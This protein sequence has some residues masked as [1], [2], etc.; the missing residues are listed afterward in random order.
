[1]AFRQIKAPALANAA[2]INTKLAPSAV[3]G[4]EAALAVNSIS[5]DTL[6]LHVAGTDTLAK[7]TVSHLVGSVDTDDLTEGAANLYFTDLRAQTAVAT[8]IS[9][10][11]AAEA[12]LARAAEGVNAT[13]I[14]AEATTARAAEG[15][16][17]TAISAEVT[18]AS[19]VES[20]LDAAYKLADTGL[21]TQI[22]N[23]L[24]NTDETALNSLA[25][26]VAAYESADDIFTAGI[27]AN[28]NAISAETTARI[29]D[30]STLTT[31]LGLTQDELDASQVGA[32]LSAAGAYIVGAATNYLT[33]ATSLSDAD[34]KLDAQSKANADAIAAEVTRATG[35]ESTN[36]TNISTNVT[37][38]STNATAISD[39]ASTARTNETALSDDI[40]AEITARGDADTAVRSEFAAA[41]ALQTT[42]LQTYADTAEADA[43]ATASAD[44]TTKADAA[45]TDAIAS[46]EAKDVARA[47][48]SD[49]A[50]TA[51]AGRATTLETEMDTAEGR[52]DTLEASGGSADLDTIDQTVAGGINE[53]HTD[54]NAV[55]VRV[56]TAETDITT[57][58]TAIANILTNTDEVA[59]NSLAELV[60]EFQA[61]DGTIT[62]LVNAN[63]TAISTEKARA[64]GVEA[65]NASAI[66]TEASTARAA[67]VVNANAVVT[68]AGTR[69]TADTTLQGNI[70]A[71]A[72]TRG[73]ADTAFQTE[74]DATQTG[75]G[76]GI[77]GTY[78]AT[79]A[80]NYIAAAT[81]LKDA[82]VKL[83]TQAKVN[84]D[85]IAAEITRATGVEGTNAT[86][87]ATNVSD[88][89]TNATNIAQEIVDRGI[90]DVALQ[91]NIDDVQAE[92][93]TTQAG[94]GLA[95]TGAYAQNASANYIAAAT[96]LNDADVKLDAALKVEEVRALAAEGINATA[97]SDETTRASGAE[98][99]ID[100]KVDNEVT[101]AT[102]ADGTHT[103]NIATNA[104]NIAANLNAITTEATTARAA[105]LTLTTNLD[106]EIL[107]AGIAEDANTT[108]IESEATTAR[109][110]E[111]ALSNRVGANE[112]SIAFIEENTDGAAL[113]SLTEI[114]AAFQSAD[115]NIV[116]TVTSNTTA[117]NAEATTARAAEL[118]LTNNLAAEVTRAGLAEDAN[119]TAI[120]TEATTARA[121]ESAL[122]TRMTT[123]EGNVDALELTMGSATMTTTAQNVTAAINELNA[124]AS[125]DLGA[126][127]ADL[128]TA[129]AAIVVNATAISDEE[130]RALGVEGTLSTTI[131]NN[132]TQVRSDFAAADLSIQ[133][134]LDATQT[135]AGLSAAGA[136]VAPTTSNFHDTATSLA[137]ADMKLDTA[138][139]AE[140]TRALAA[141]LVNTNAVSAEATTARAAEAL[142]ATAIT[143]EN[144]RATGVEGTLST[145][146]AAN[147]TEI[148]ATQSGAGLSVAGAYVAPTTSNYHN[149]ATSLASAD[150]K[151]DAALKAEADR[152][153]AAEGVNTTAISDEATRAGLAEVANFD[154]VTAEAVTARAAELA[155]A[156]SISTVSANLATE[157]T[158]RTNADASL[159]TQVDFITSNVDA[160]SLDS[161]TE[162]V[163][164]FQTA[165][166]DLLT[167]VTSNTTAI[168]TEATT[169]RAAEL[170]NA[171][172]VAAEAT[173]ARA[174]EGVNAA[175]VTS[176]ETRAL[177]AEGILTTAVDTK[178]AKSGS[179]M[180]GVLNMGGNAISGVA[181]PSAATD[182]A[183]KGYVD[184]VISSQDISTYTTDDL[185]E[186]SNLYFT[187]TRAQAAISVVDTEGTGRVSYAAG[188]VTVDTQKSFLELTDYIGGESDYSASVNYV[189]VVNAAGTGLELVDPTTVLVAETTRQTLSGDGATTTFALTMNVQT[190]EDLM[191]FVG[192][193]IQDPSTHYTVD[194]SANTITFTAGAMPTG[195]QAVVVGHQTGYTLSQGAVTSEKLAAD[196]K[197]FIQSGNV[198]AT[199]GGDVIDTFD[200]TTYRSAK[201]VIQVSDSVSGEYETRE[202]LV[203]HDGSAAYITEFAMVYTGASLIGD[204]SVAMNGTNVELTYTTSSVTAS[205]KVISTYIN[206]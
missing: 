69:A 52:L 7:I 28:G 123:E 196:I 145:D 168:T 67:E 49:A 133:Q 148:T 204:A 91:D 9:T 201:Y 184:G 5:A 30:V 192:G 1:M 197:P 34:A 25:E 61:A 163:S 32:G 4:Q 104:T 72:T 143:T 203:I 81:S 165:D 10:A 59:L 98:S 66:T 141:E 89:A 130:T 177:A 205:V 155:N 202:A 136:Y 112:T 175:A 78:T 129:E 29:S 99:L 121:A 132:D 71:E 26:I 164:A 131:G 74:L 62:G 159:Q 105:E 42:A 51:L 35:V 166:G 64:E 188:V 95:A 63:A 3:S 124:A 57:N 146:I 120:T 94:A 46:A 176:E 79:A 187:D 85:A 186:G 199:T 109:A 119:T 90:A 135:G 45:E 6:L 60:A 172:L 198:S 190:A 54:T 110:A 162:I 115:G 200:G 139:K 185:A 101:R 19:G 88:I 11:V 113:D 41:D 118:L 15:V 20:A 33:A 147:L 182:A 92:L 21:Q 86:N 173:T 24:N 158:D 68:E 181:T 76:L 116:T 180:T 27:L 87:I 170:A 171:N 93:D 14:S 191:V 84:A 150:M 167:T 103:T 102:A 149:T 160:A 194:S 100:T 70:D 2:V 157:I 179:T 127:Q 206:V 152:A 36:A 83:D 75:A 56:S 65:T 125:S 108:A 17:D 53:L 111:L 40:Q 178:V 153:L 140:E 122:A 126:I 161:L 183:S 138:I 80:A 13:A 73:D 55:A 97:I 31:S 18:R 50:D 137:S 58:A 16:N 144:T 151:I 174:A 38:I 117:I 22:N 114:V 195:T 96:S 43:I 44:A 106:A 154:L 47:V 128:D 39:E 189:A 23:I 107:R 142:N 48:T 134:E 169:A 82:D 37:N 12:V 77:D 156:N 193:V 8:D